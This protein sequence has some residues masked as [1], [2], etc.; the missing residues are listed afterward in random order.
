M[1]QSPQTK[2]PPLLPLYAILSEQFF[3]REQAIERLKKRFSGESNFDFNY[4]HFDAATAQGDAIVAAANTLPFAS[5]H[6]LIIVNNIHEAKNDLLAALVDYAQS[7]SSTTV[8]AV[9]GEKLAKSTRLYKAIDNVGGI[10]ARTTPKKKE[11][12]TVVQQLFK[13]QGKI[14]S[15]KLAADI[16]SSVGEDLEALNT[17]IAKTATYIGQRTEVTKADIDATI[18]A[19]AEVK[20]WDLIDALQNRDGMQSLSLY[21]LLLK[22]NNSMYLIAPTVT[23]TVRELIIARSCID[24]GAGSPA[25][26]ASA[27]GKPEWLARKTFEGAKRYA[28]VELRDALAQLA[29]VEFKLK[30]SREGEAAFERFLIDFTCV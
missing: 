5:E 10:V 3:L 19:S 25:Q 21:R 12:P 23:R 29:D 22:Q 4:D 16:V 17:A 8:L 9:A 30:T 1:T 2:Q 13:N 6:R 14:I 28:A 24:T 18:E 15:L 7:P 11:L 26:V 27:L 20:V